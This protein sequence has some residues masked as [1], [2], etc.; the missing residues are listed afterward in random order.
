MVVWGLFGK[1]VIAM[2]FIRG[3]KRAIYQ[4]KGYF[5]TLLSNV[6]TYMIRLISPKI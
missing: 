6:N 1:S 4:M 3:F 5:F 2:S